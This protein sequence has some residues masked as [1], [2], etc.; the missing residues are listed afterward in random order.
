MSGSDPNCTDVVVIGGGLAGLTAAIRARE[1]GR[2]V[3]LVDPDPLTGA[4]ANSRISGGVF[5]LAWGAMDEPPDRLLDRMVEQTDGEVDPALAR[6]LATHAAPAIGWLADHG[7][8]LGPKGDRPHDRFTCEPWLEAVG[9]SIRPERGAELALAQLR[10]CATSLGVNTVGGCAESLDRRS[11]HWEVGCRS[12]AGVDTVVGVEVIM[13]T[14]GF[15]A[16]PDLMRRYVGPHADQV[17]LRSTASSTGRG[18]QLLLAA[19]AALTD[20]SSPVYGHLLSASATSEPRLWPQPTVDA[21]A[22][23]GLLVDRT[24]RAAG[25]CA[26]TGIGLVNAM[27]RTDDPSGYAVVF[28]ADARARATAETDDRGSARATQTDGHLRSVAELVE[29][30]AD[31]VDAPGVRELAERLGVPAETL[32]E[33]VANWRGAR[34]ESVGPTHWYGMRVLPGVTTTTR[35]VRV[36]DLCRVVTPAGAPLA[37]LRA[38]G[39]VVGAHGGPRG[40]YL[41]G[42]AVALVTGF[43]AGARV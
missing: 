11:A 6:S 14:G 23:R 32:E 34:G 12:S 2:D 21:V 9:D 17:F 41:G 27:V 20:P 43:V 15:Q 42:Y 7:V 1:S 18:M 31:I 36:D 29:R 10:S 37:G 8:K 5:H 35:G 30:G 4:G 13:A 33:S 22:R 19:G 38:A 39:D 25:F 16:N 24:G 26:E 28:D 40:G 3:T